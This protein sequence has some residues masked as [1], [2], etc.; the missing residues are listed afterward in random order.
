MAHIYFQSYIAVA[1]FLNNFQTVNAIEVGVSHLE[2]VTFKASIYITF[3]RF[4]RSFSRLFLHRGCPEKMGHRGVAFP[5]RGT[6]LEF[7]F[8]IRGNVIEMSW[9]DMFEE[10]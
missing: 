4:K 5:F 9:V 10:C 3:M 1:N 7:S 8:L 6:G 2:R